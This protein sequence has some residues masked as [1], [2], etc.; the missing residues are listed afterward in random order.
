MYGSCNAALDTYNN[1]GDSGAFDFEAAFGIGP[2]ATPKASK[3]LANMD[4]TGDPH[5][6]NT[7]ISRWDESQV[8]PTSPPS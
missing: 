3:D 5:D 6:P 8:I 1:S 2:G 4:L 7:G